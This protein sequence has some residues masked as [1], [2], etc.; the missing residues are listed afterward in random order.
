MNNN[1][2]FN[3]EWWD[4]NPMTYEDWNLPK[5]VRSSI[6]I[7]KLKKINS[8]Y[9]NDNPYLNVFFKN[10]KNDNQENIV[11]DIGCGWGT[12]AV[13]LSKIFKEVYSIDI[14]EK[15]VYAAKE[16][17]RLNGIPEKVKLKTYD[18]EELDFTNYF[19]FVYSWGVIHHSHD[20]KKILVNIYRGLKENGQC[21]IMIY[22]K[23]SLRYYLKGLYYL[24][25]KFKIFSGYNLQS[26]Q[27]L[28]TDGFYQK[29][30]SQSELRKILKEIGFKNI[31]FDLTHMSKPYLP[32]TKKNSIID[33][34][35]KKNFG[36]L[37]VAKLN[38]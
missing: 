5:N 31:N 7:D 25:F 30:Y 35:L 19:D 33:K 17:V 36:W 1:N 9:I 8:A 38:K 3:K 11:L 4:K 34:F 23:N 10:L 29:H 37:L 12:S 15:A 6:D 21:L 14:S 18:A 32:F 28:F 2:R 26:V 27:K 16:N 22:N 24:I 13:I 20:T